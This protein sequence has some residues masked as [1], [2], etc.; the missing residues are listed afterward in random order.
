MLHLRLEIEEAKNRG[1]KAR[2]RKK[3]VDVQDGKR[4][5]L[6]FSLLG[7][8]IRPPCDSQGVDLRLNWPVLHQSLRTKVE[9]DIG[10]TPLAHVG[11]HSAVVMGLASSLSSSR[12]QHPLA[13]FKLRSFPR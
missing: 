3:A 10:T 4:A 9:F 8:Y 7:I 6:W 13:H 5:V 11:Q 2:K 12:P 1:R